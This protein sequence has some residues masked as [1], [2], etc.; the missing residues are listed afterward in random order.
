MIFFLKFKLIDT[1]INVNYFRANNANSQ[2]IVNDWVKNKSHNLLDDFKIPSNTRA[3][4]LNLI[5]FNGTWVEPFATEY[6]VEMPF[7]LNEQKQMKATYMSGQQDIFYVED[8]TDLKLKMIR[9]PYKSDNASNG[10]V[11]MYVILPNDHNVKKIVENLN[12]D[13]FESLV[14]KMRDDTVDI[15]M[16]KLDLHTN[17]DIKEH[18]EYENVKQNFSVQYRINTEK[19]NEKLVLTNIFQE[20]RLQVFETGIISHM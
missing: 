10:T 3:I 1:T 4:F 5:F 14:G 17:I 13:K 8:K 6:T 7:N 2:K 12:F 19:K 11:A 15:R 16:P 20:V 18:L 9:L